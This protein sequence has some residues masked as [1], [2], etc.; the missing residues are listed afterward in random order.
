MLRRCVNIS[1]YL[2][3]AELTEEM[4]Q[5]AEIVT[6]VP[7]HTE[8]LSEPPYTKEMLEALQKNYKLGIVTS[9]SRESLS[10][11]YFPFSHTEKCFSVRVALEDCARHKPHPEP[12]LLATKRLRLLP[13]DCVYVG[14]A[15]TDIE[16]GKAAGMKTILYGGKKNKDADITTTSFKTLPALIASLG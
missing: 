10:K 8:L 11:R 7:Y 3:K 5:L 6:K 12:L 14:D 4:K 13:G 9:R 2:S 15:H 1:K 16:A